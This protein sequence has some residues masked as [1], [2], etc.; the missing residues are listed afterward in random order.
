M[1][2][3]CLPFAGGGAS[4]YR[5][6]PGYFP[7]DVEVVPIQLPTVH[8]DQDVPGARLPVHQALA[9]PF[10]CDP[11]LMGQAPGHQAQCPVLLLH[12]VGGRREHGV[13]RGQRHA[14]DDAH[15]G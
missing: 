10:R 11:V 13:E 14:F 12:G 1:R 7:D 9:L 4:V 3:F 8:V 2:L 5:E 6:W 15:G